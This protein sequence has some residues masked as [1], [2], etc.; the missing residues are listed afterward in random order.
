LSYPPSALPDL[1]NRLFES[2]VKGTLNLPRR[3]ALNFVVGVNGSGK[4]SILRTLYRI[5]VALSRR[6]RPALPVT[7]AWDRQVGQGTRTAVLHTTTHRDRRSF[8]ATLAQV[9]ADTNGAGWETLTRALGDAKP[10]PLAEDLDIEHGEAS[11][12]L[13]VSAGLLPGCYRAELLAAGRIRERRLTLA[14]LHR[15]TAVR[16]I[17]SVRGILPCRVAVA[18]SSAAEFRLRADKNSLS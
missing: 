10:H 17:N 13:P 3:G 5:F 1:R 2:L 11:V 7:L 12:Q 8:F 18:A 9:P 14:D 4:S 15:A 16:A 6:E